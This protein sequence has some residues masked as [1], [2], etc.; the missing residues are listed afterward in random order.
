[1]SYTS[2]G[3]FISVHFHNNDKPKPRPEPFLTSFFSG[4]CG[5]CIFPL[6]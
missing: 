1:M 6:K 3:I 2:E 4:H 5:D